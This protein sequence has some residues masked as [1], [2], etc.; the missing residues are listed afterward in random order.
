MASYEQFLRNFTEEEKRTDVVKIWSALATNTEKTILEEMVAQNYEISDINNFN[1]ETYES[2]LGFF[3]RKIRNRVAPRCRIKVT[4]I[5][6]ETITK[7]ESGSILNSPSG[8]YIQDGEINTL[9]VNQSAIVSVIQGRL[10]KNNGIKYDNYIQINANNVD[11][12]TIVIKHSSSGKIINEVSYTKSYGSLNNRGSCCYDGNNLKINDVN[13]TDDIGKFGDYYSILGSGQVLNNSLRTLNHTYI[14]NGDMIIHDGNSWTLN[15]HINEL[16]PYQLEYEYAI[17]RNGYYAY[18]SDGKLYIKIFQGNEVANPQNE[19]YDIEYIVTD[20]VQGEVKKGVDVFSYEENLNSMVSIENEN[21]SN[22]VS[23]IT[24]GQLNTMLRQSFFCGVSISSMPEYNAWFNSQAEIGNAYVYSDY[25][26]WLRTN[27]R[28]NSTGYIYVLALD[29]NNI[30]ITEDVARTLAERIE[31]YKDVGFLKFENAREIKVCFEVRYKSS[32]D[33]DKLNSIINST[34]RSYFDP[35]TLRERGL[36]V[37]DDLDLA[38]IIREID[39]SYNV[40]GIDVLCFHFYKDTIRNGNVLIDTTDEP[41]GNAQYVLSRKNQNG[42]I[43]K[44]EI[45]E[46]PTF[47]PSD[48]NTSTIKMYD[49]SNNI[50]DVGNRYENKISLSNIPNYEGYTLEVKIPTRNSAILTI[51]DMKSYRNLIVDSD[52]VKAIDIKRYSN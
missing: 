23:D 21:S 16:L 17:P 46:V 34:I 40:V 10:V 1:K 51:D 45:W 6:D 20:G 42:K 15:K 30:P 50:I 14:T 7:I 25:E 26:Q 9:E 36:T 33:D 5:G 18:S 28:G 32:S 38:Q 49:D 35:N 43:E 41:I 44:K 11:L 31:P 47:S 27:R 13:L 19:L 3:M 29:R 48:T 4:N 8:T 22:G 12:D 52:T 2:W 39:N 24:R 37:F